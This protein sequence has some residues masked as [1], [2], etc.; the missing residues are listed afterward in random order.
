VKPDCEMGGT[1][2]NLSNSL[3][4]GGTYTASRDDI[5][6][7]LPKAQDPKFE[8]GAIPAAGPQTIPSGKISPPSIPDLVRKE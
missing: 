7:E 2:N 3:R 8:S 5:Q 1:I 6:D 4:K